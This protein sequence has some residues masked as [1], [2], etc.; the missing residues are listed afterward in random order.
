MR[1]N[2]ILEPVNVLVFLPAFFLAYAL[3]FLLAYVLALLAFWSQR[4]DA[5]LS[6]N[7]TLVF[8]F[9][10]QVAPIALLPGVLQ[11]AALWL[12]Y[13]Y[14]LSF[15]VELLLGGM[16]QNQVLAGFAGQLGWLLAAFML[17]QLVWKRGL[18]HYTAVGG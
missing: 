17:H 2:V 10:G 8:L 4:A 9:A 14:M 12:P 13:R 3:R 7:D 15:P 16:S 11:A 5:L 6:L 1:P 18:R